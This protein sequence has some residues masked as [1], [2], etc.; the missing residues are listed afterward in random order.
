MSRNFDWNKIGV[1]S[2]PSGYS[3]NKKF[4]CPNCRDHRG[5]PADKSLSVNLATGQFY[6][7]HCQWSGTIATR[8]AEETREWMRQQDWYREPQRKN[9][10]K[11]VLPKPLPM[12]DEV[13]NWFKRRGISDSV[14]R[15]AQVSE[16]EEYVPQLKLTRRCIQ[17]PFFRGGELVN[18]KFRDSEQKLFHQ[19]TGAELI[20][21]NMDAIEHAEECIIVEGE[22]DA[23]SFMVAGKF[24]VVSVPSGANNNL[25]WL[26][27]CYDTHFA[28]K[29]CIYIAVD[30]DTKGL[31]L[32]KELLRRFS[33]IPTKIV[34]FGKVCKDA[35]ELLMGAGPNA[36]IAMLETAEEPKVEGVFTASDVEDELNS[37]YANGWKRGVTIGIREIDEKLSLETQRL[38]VVTGI[39]GSGKSEFI[40]E[41]MVRLNVR[42]GWR[43]AV[44]SPENQPLAYHYAKLISKYTGKYFRADKLPL[45]EYNAA[46]DRLDHDFFSVL[47]P[48]YDLDSILMAAKELVKRRGIKGLVIDPYNRLEVEDGGEISETNAISKMLDRLTN[49]AQQNDLLVVLMAHPRKMPK[50]KDD[51]K[52]EMPTMYD[53]NGSA[54]FYNKADFGVIV[55]RQPGEPFTQIKIAKV[56]FRNLGE[57]GECTL[58]W[59]KDNGRYESNTVDTSRGV[60]DCTNWVEFPEKCGSDRGQQTNGA[61]PQP[62]AVTVV[63][64]E[65]ELPF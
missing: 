58:A 54:N 3:G 65:Q 59:N 38:M 35:N 30:T 8:S 29:S 25:D 11:P 55:H 51:G 2:P 63:S 16:C 42:E 13:H 61:A 12:S 21:Y 60:Y 53:I 7:H 50:C 48:K 57:P 5:N 40:D 47:P 62:A 20:P 36:L 9:D 34:T 56:K 23:L 24:N 18:I 49:F 6:C 39:P 32:R 41:I 17:F 28:N 33:D 64:E 15:Y 37:L 4:T 46:K 44:F 52:I 1:T 26:T 14:L 19:V 27:A 43:W 31:D 45:H 22:M 10:T